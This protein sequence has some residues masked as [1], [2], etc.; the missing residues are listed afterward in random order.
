MG[1]PAK[2]DSSIAGSPSG[3]P[4]IL[5]KR[6]GRAARAQSAFASAIDVFVSNAIVGYSSSDT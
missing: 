3:V 2:I 5:M 4:G 6:F 1:T